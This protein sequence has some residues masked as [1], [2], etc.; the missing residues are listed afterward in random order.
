[1]AGAAT[2]TKPGALASMLI[3]SMLI[4]STLIASTLIASTP[5]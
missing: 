4:A 5:R 2:V 1:V 3:A